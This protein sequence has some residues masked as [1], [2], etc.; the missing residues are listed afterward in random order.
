MHT[1][2]NYSY[3]KPN[4]TRTFHQLY[5]FK[6]LEISLFLTDNMNKC[7]EESTLVAAIILDEFL[8]ETQ[9]LI[10]AEKFQS[11]AFSAL[12]NQSAFY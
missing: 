9:S 1:F 4:S 7:K 11:K 6:K 2:T 12:S 3:N 10:H 5:S 8:I